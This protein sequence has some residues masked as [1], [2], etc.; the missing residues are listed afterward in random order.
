MLMRS[1]FL[2]LALAS[3]AAAGVTGPAE[4]TVEAGKLTAIPLEVSGD[5]VRYAILGGDTFGAFRE[6]SAPT[7]FRLQVLGYRA[8]V[9]YVVF[10]AVK[11][12]QLAPLFVVTVR[13]TGGPA[14]GP[15]PPPVPPGP[16]PGPDPPKPAGA[17]VVVIT[18]QDADSVGLAAVLAGTKFR[19]QLVGW[20]LKL[21]V[22][23]KSGPEVRDKGYLAHAKDLPALLV[24]DKDGRVLSAVKCPA[25]EAGAIEAV[26]KGA[27]K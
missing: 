1:L 20:G 9:G 27:G 25:D 26:R 7:E 3:P 24:I 21:H 10:G 6:F 14:P 15:T 16:G 18:D 4:V 17:W 5:Q 13:V 23:D 8:G 11:D 22:Y 12:G 2:A 19:Q